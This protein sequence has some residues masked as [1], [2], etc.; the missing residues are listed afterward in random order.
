M[1]FDIWLVIL[2]VVEWALLRTRKGM[3]LDIAGANSLE[4]L[5]LSSEGL[6]GA[7]ARL[8]TITRLWG[9]G[10]ILAGLYL[11]IYPLGVLLITAIALFVFRIHPN[12][13][14]PAYSVAYT[15]QTGKPAKTIWF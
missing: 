10:V 12:Q 3:I 6:I 15:A 5:G 13:L 8:L 4:A 7:V 1:K 14:G 9:A 11:S 2:V